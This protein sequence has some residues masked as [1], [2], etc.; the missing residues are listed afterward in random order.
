MTCESSHPWALLDF[1]LTAESTLI[2]TIW[3]TEP[4]FGPVVLRYCV[5]YC[6]GWICN[7]ASHS[8]YLDH[9]RL[10]CFLLFTCVRVICSGS[11]SVGVKYFEVVTELWFCFLTS[12]L[13]MLHFKLGYRIVNLPNYVL[14]FY[15][16]SLWAWDTRHIYVFICICGITLF[17]R[18][19]L[20][21]IF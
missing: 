1:V 10:F 19:G 6:C 5:I 8:L 9:F 21:K 18:I 11:L 2:L 12:N 15:Q 20:T 16:T 14:D 4:H 13:I 7:H 3:L 17:L